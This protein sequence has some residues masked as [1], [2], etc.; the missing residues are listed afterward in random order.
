MKAVCSVPLDLQKPATKKKGVNKSSCLAIIYLHVIL[1]ILN[2]ENC[3][4]VITLVV[5][6]GR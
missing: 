4:L 1:S 2:C 6:E 5:Q 3:L